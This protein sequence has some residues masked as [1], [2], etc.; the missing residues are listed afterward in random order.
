MVIGMNYSE[1]WLKYDKISNYNLSD[2][3]LF[4]D[5]EGETKATAV[6]EL[7]E[8][9]L[10]LYGRKLIQAGNEAEFLEK[11]AGVW[12]RIDAS[13]SVSKEGYHI[14][15]TEGRCILTAASK[16]G[17][18]YGVFALLRNLVVFQVENYDQWSFEERKE[19][20][21]PLRMLNHWDNMDGSIE[22][23]YSGKSFFF[24]EEEI[25]LNNR[26]RDYAR[27]AASV[28]INGVVINNV[29]VKGAAT[30]LI[31]DRYYDKLKLLS[32]LFT[33][34]GIKLFLSINFAAP[35]EL[36]GLS[37]ADPCRE[38]VRSWWTEK[39]KEVWRKVPALGGFLIKADSEGRPGPFTYGR[40]HADGANMLAEAVKPFGGLIIWRCFVYNC[41]QDW[42]DTRTDRARAGYDNFMPLDGSFAEQVILQI[43]NGPMD[44][45]V[46]EPISPLFGG[47]KKTNMMLEVQIAQEYTGQQRH[48]CYLLPWFKQI[49]DFRTHCGSIQDR[50]AEIISGRTYQNTQ[51]GIVA[52]A[53]TGNDDNWTGHDLAAANLY[54]FG[55]LAF[56]PELTAKEI[57]EEWIVQT[58]GASKKVMDNVLKILTESWPAYEKYTSPLGIG[59]MVKPNHHYGP[60][61]DGYE[62]D[63]WGTYHRADHKGIG[64]DRTEK[65]TGYCLQYNEPLAG[66]YADRN[67]CP[68]ELLLFF[69]HVEYTHL[70]SSGKTV[71]QHI[72]DTHFEGAEEAKQFHE[73]WKELE[74]ELEKAAYERTRE[75][76]LHQELHSAEWC[77]VINSYFYRKTG[78]ADQLGRK[79]Y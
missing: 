15:C 75:R 68:E 22:R 67:T 12:L 74:G 21:Q 77:D 44:F 78:I 26:T 63:R 47:L 43:K 52:V 20:Y 3:A 46:R 28:G 13:Q 57:A 53:N 37:T 55:R 35:I 79:L 2:I 40:T 8:G 32:E 54:G 23:G 65:G 25:L 31:S 76:F 5:F 1:A 66:Q 69:H 60:D 73:L 17:V 61:V 6:K 51:G 45:Q 9:F 30:A 42:R 27:M 18:L 14:S 64:V 50:I 4:C 38:E 48:V 70:L 72:Y 59:W 16:A 49:L 29:N 34:Y 33:A 41:Q 7:E 62:Y 58:F 11:R 24:Q 39:S 56:D 71:L 19:P 10:R 36:G